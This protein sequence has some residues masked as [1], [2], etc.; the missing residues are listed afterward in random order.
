VSNRYDVIIETGIIGL[1]VYMTLTFGGVLEGSIALMEIVVSLLLVVWLLKLL[2]QRSAVP[3]N[4]IKQPGMSHVR[5]VTSPLLLVFALFSGLVIFQLL[6]LPAFLVRFLSPETYRVYA[7][8]ASQINTPLPACLPLSVCSYATEAELRKLLAYLMVFIMTV[9]NIRSPR[10]I[11]RVVYVIIALGLFESLYGMLEYFSG[12]QH[13]LFHKKTG[14]LGV[15]GTFVNKNHFAGFM[16]MTIPLTFS[17]LFARLTER[18]QASSKTLVRFMD[19]KYMK[20]L[21]TSFLLAIMIVALILSSSRGGVVS[22]VCGMFCFMGLAYNRRLLRKGVLV[23][24]VLIVISGGL[25]VFM[26][27]D[28]IM[29]RLHTFTQLGTET[30]FQ[31]RRHIWIDTLSIIRDFPVFGS[32]F[33]TFSHLFPRYQ[34]F[35]SH[36]AV[37]YA[38]NDYLQ[39][40]AE[41]GG[42]GMFL[43]VCGGAFFFYHTLRAWKQR[44]S[45]W[46]IVV[47]VGGISAVCSIL[48]HSS[49]DFNLHIPSNALLFSVI[50]ALT[51]TAAHSR[52]RSPR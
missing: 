30:S 25:S 40:L 46:P 31:L 24:L 2:S 44:H 19:E 9:N 23:I 4:A 52:R 5:I 41:T 16:E 27:Y 49:V 7:D 12:H 11:T 39:T 10:Q 37:L 47:T 20:V 36:L 14:S 48:V 35:S 28:L 18:S 26:G 45:R 1:L 33:G 50:A 3:H 29:T 8:A 34:T 22:F 13:I 17:L 32:G 38:E 42:A 51:M 43:I 21:L 6:P 15:S